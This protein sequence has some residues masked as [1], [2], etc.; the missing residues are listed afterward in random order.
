MT[1][2][3]P[4]LP[5]AWLMRLGDNSLILGHRM[6]EW[7]SCAPTLEE[8]IALSNLG[9]DLIGQTRALYTRACELEAAGRTEDMLAY[10]RPE[11][12]FRNLLLVE[13]PNG[14][15]AETM[16]RH[17]IFSAYMLPLYEALKGSS[18]A[19]VAGIATRSANEMAYHLRHS[20]EW[21]IRL[22]DGTGESHARAQEALDD[23]WA[24]VPELFETDDLDRAVAASGFGVDPAGLRG[25]FDATISEVLKRATLKR[26]ADR[27]GIRG[28]R[29]GV[30]SEHLGHML[31][32]MQHLQR[33][34]PDAVW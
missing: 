26:P 8:D 12:E 21:M 17:L 18:D 3:S 24:Y 9:L 30:H 10:R 34:Y 25:A 27:H 7:V 22:G 32:T 5:A 23:L 28:G 13:Q 15:F 1:H 29:K 19:D 6:S 33:A 11:E 16:A 20:A 2:A 14:N 31:A 4:N